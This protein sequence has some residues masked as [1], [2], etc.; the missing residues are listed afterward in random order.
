MKWIVLVA[1]ALMLAG[2]II[3][4]AKRSLSLQ[5][6]LLGGRRVGPW[7]SALSYGS[8]YFS[9]VILIGYAGTVGWQVGTAAV[10]VGVG[11]AVIGSWLAWSLLAKPTRL[12]GEK[13][14]VSTIPGFFE[15]RYG[16]R[17]MKLLS[18]TVIFVFLLP[19]SASVYRGLGGIFQRAMGMDYTL[20]ML[21]VA[22][23]SGLYLFFGGYKATALTD[24]IQ[25]SIMAVGMVVVVIYVVNGAGG[26]TQGMEALNNL[27]V[28]GGTYGSLLPPAGKGS[29]LL[30][31][32]L[33]TSVGVL[34]MPQ[35]VHKFFA[36]RDEDS[37]RRAKVI[38]TVFALIVAGGAY[39]AGGFSRAILPHLSFDGQISQFEAVS[40]GLMP[41][42][43]IMPSILTDPIRVAMPDA[44]QGLLVVLLLSASISTLTGLVLSSASVIS[45]DL[46][47]T[48]IPTM[49]SRTTTRIMRGLCLLFV[50]LSLAINFLMQ[51]TPIMSLMSL[52]WGAIAGAFLAP[53]LYGLLWKGANRFGALAGAA[54]GLLT[55]ILPPVVTG[56]FSTTPLW[57]IIAMG[58]S[59]VTVPLVS[60]LMKCA[61]S[62]SFEEG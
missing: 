7:L 58:V 5:D 10:W 16:S 38:S 60:L 46:I 56:D 30:T 32:V 28:S 49:P 42:D 22:T 44:F 1:Y 17:F 57:G 20:T 27:S 51:G 19:Y 15:K 50:L 23:L 13:L 45:V 12:M 52:S 55:A 26:L 48:L 53:F 21:L 59:L 39:F 41:M 33:L 62:V 2:M 14:K 34:G 25:A 9:A 4:T 31:N 29:W 35:M 3:F 36:I 11:N 8:S 40:Q 18:A 43:H 54:V 61:P 47:G 24:V 6:F 37:I